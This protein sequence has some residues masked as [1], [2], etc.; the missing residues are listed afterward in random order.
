MSRVGLRATLVTA[1]IVVALIAMVLLALVSARSVRDLVIEGAL[2]D[3]ELLA[4][5]LASEYDQFLTMHLR[6]VSALAAHVAAQPQLTSAALEPTVAR[7]RR[8]LQTVQGLA[9]VDSTGRVLTVDP[10]TSPDG[11]PLVGLDLSSRDWFQA[12]RASPRPMVGWGVI[13]TAVTR[14]LAVTVNAPVLTARDEFV[15]AV[16]AVVELGTLQQLADRIR[17]GKT[18]YAQATTAIGRALVHRDLALVRG[19][20]DFS[21]MPIWPWV[22][23]A[24]AGRVPEYIG[25]LGDRRLAGFATVP[26]VGWKIWV[27][28]SLDE[29]EGEIAAIYRRLLGW[30]LAALAGTIVVA[31]F[32][33]GAI[34]RPVQDLRRRAGAVAA[35]DLD[36]RAAEAGPREV[37]ELSRAFNQMAASLQ[38]RLRSE[39]EAQAEL[40][41]T[42]AA[43]AEQNRRVE[44]A[45]RHK[46]EFLA[47]MSHE[48]RT[49]LNAV[50]GFS[51][52][53]HDGKV[54]AVNADQR[55]FLG[56]ILTSS[57]H[58]LQLI[59][60]VL[61]LA[62]VEAG[63]MEFRPEP[64]SVS[65]VA[66]EVRDVLRPLAARKRIALEVEV[67]PELHEVVADPGRVRQI[68]Y[69]YVSNA[70]KFTDADGR[71]VIRA[72]LEPP[73][74]F[75]LEVE[76][77]GI[78]ISGDDVGRLF[79]DFHQLDAS[80]AKRYAGTGLGLALTRR[81]V[82]A[83][84]GR[85]G[86]RS[87][88][89]RGSTFS[90]VLPL[91]ALAGSASVGESS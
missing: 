46:S 29:V 47:N 18:G 91:V 83:L 79:Q 23:A 64:L 17:I 88:P 69:N 85:V 37:R 55:E 68:L 42:N 21:A 4:R 89:G 90:A 56:D 14:E 39:R 84:G 31:L 87:M 27:N 40:H 70:I 80:T 28:Q 13:T 16:T 58:L 62:K 61:D 6:D 44:E 9:V 36:Q 1:M 51:E 24:D 65:G 60:D 7:H 81:L 52:L 57:R 75:R 50:I 54:G 45:S 41:A 63:R 74:A 73:E 43:L 8:S 86:V 3:S 15:G 77:T 33:T 2:T 76:D 11:K 38:Q 48:L 78:G 71:I 26:G 5:G 20:T 25:A 53:M 35:G 67:S 59:D 19:A 72:S 82:E 10:P 32:I 49:P 66:G 30:A 12:M 22:T 34:S